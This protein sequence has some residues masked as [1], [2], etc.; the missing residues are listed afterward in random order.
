MP[1][2]VIREDQ[3]TDLR[4]SGLLAKALDV[5][6]DDTL[7]LEKT[8]FLFAAEVHGA[9]QTLA[10]AAYGLGPGAEIEALHY[11]GGGSAR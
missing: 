10:A 4:I 5:A 8:G 7:C 11:F 3:K 1:L 9:V 6:C 2:R